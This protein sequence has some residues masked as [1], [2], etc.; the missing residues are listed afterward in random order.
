MACSREGNYGETLLSSSSW[1]PAELGIMTYL[2]ASPSRFSGSRF[3]L[4]LG[5]YMQWLQMMLV[6][7][8]F[9]GA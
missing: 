9:T 7:P 6:E 4:A 1:Q 2:T 8:R 3:R 5:L